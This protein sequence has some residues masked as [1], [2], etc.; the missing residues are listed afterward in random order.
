MTH[1]ENIDENEN[2]TCIYC[3]F[4]YSRLK[5]NDYWIQYQMCS[6]CCHTQYADITIRKRCL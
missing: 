3:N 5:S 2:A 4:L 6:K 1:I